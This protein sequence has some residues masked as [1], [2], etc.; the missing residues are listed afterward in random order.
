MYVD[1]AGGGENGDE[2]VAT[3]TYFLHGYI[4][5]AETLALSGGYGDDKYM[6][7]SQLALKHGVN[8]I[9][10]EKNFGYGAFA[11]AWR[12]IIQRVYKEAGKNN[13]PRIED[14]WESGQKEL[15]I[16]DC[17]E[18]IMARHR[19]IV[20]EDIIEYDQHSVKKYP[21]DQQESYKVFHQLSK[22]SRDKGALIHDDRLDSLAGSCRKWVERIAVDEQVRMA[23]K[24][25]DENVD[26]FAQWGGDIGGNQNGVLGLSSD[27]FSKHVKQKRALKARNTSARRRR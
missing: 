10:V 23:Q 22:I 24:E 3:V 12:P 18:P 19:L 9:D 15:R 8:S 11:S 14:V 20:H 27:R 7:L 5:W 16:I 13:C 17:L 25:T 21:I 6:A 4:F 2:T 26:F 1:T